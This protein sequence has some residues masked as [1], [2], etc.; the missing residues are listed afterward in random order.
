MRAH[1]TRPRGRLLRHARQ[2]YSFE[3]ADAYAHETPPRRT[4]VQPPH[5]PTSFP[6]GRRAPAPRHPPPQAPSHL[7]GARSRRGRAGAPCD[8][9]RGWAGSTV[10]GPPGR[11]EPLGRGSS[12]EFMMFSYKVRVPPVRLPPLDRSN[13]TVHH[14]VGPNPGH[15]PRPAACSGMFAAPLRA[16]ARRC[17]A[18]GVGCDGPGTPPPARR[19]QL[20]RCPTPLGAC[21]W[22]RVISGTGEPAL[23]RTLHSKRRPETVPQGQV[24]RRA[25]RALRISSLT[26]T[27][28]PLLMVI[29]APPLR[30]PIPAAMTGAPVLHAPR[31]VG[32]PSAARGMRR[33]GRAAPRHALHCETTMQPCSH[34]A[35]QPAAP[36]AG[37][38]QGRPLPLVAQPAHW[39]RPHRTQTAAPLLYPSQ[40]PS[41]PRPA[42]FTSTTGHSALSRTEGKRRAGETRKS[43]RTSRRPAPTA[44]GCG[45]PGPAGR[46]RVGPMLAA[47]GCGLRGWSPTGG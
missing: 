37:P 43:T 40:P 6:C 15:S 31:D 7:P 23:A 29:P 13:T 12:V 28:P 10:A 26:A 34:A 45:A 17:S 44:S 9:R 32:A 21:R 4:S 33:S 25:G 47:G 3:I 27:S 41:R 1:H 42:T 5:T 39:P 8:A 30:H 11:M 35:M 16:H 36:A 22:C 18:L 20:S 19:L 14:G 46:A 24:A 2:R 38:C